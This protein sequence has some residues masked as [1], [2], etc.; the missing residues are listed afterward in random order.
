MP[1]I[2]FKSVIIV[3]YKAKIV[4]QGAKV[5]CMI[6]GRINVLCHKKTGRVIAPVKKL[7]C[8]YTNMMIGK[9]L[10]YFQRTTNSQSLT[11]P[12]LPFAKRPKLTLND[13]NSP[14]S[15]DLHTKTL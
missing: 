5:G 8:L 12:K 1:I 15:N 14:F 10:A 4:K 7:K 3:I 13:V 2:I 9:N 11:D 6:F